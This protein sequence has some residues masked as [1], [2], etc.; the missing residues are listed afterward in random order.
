MKYNISFSD[1]ANEDI[2]LLKKSGDQGVLKKFGKLLQELEEHPE[3]GTGKPEL[4]KKNL[5]GF[6]SREISQKHRL[7]YRIEEETITV[8][9]IQCYGHYNDK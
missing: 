6:W 1:E 5:S 2:A 8:I 3:T 7:V 9:V 4:L